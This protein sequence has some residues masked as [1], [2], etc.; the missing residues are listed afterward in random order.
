MYSYVLSSTLGGFDDSTVALDS[1]RISSV[2]VVMSGDMEDGGIEGR[3]VVRMRV[4]P[5]TFL[6]LHLRIGIDTVGVD[7]PQSI[8]P[9]DRPCIFLL[10]YQCAK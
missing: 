1:C 8:L 2:V 10:D 9:D 4:V 5:R 7:G 3:V 6:L